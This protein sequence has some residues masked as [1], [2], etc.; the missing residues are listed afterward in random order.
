[1]VTS[2][3]KASATGTMPPIRKTLVQPYDGTT[4]A[5]VSPHSDAPIR[6]PQAMVLTRNALMRAGAYS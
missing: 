4:A 2:M 3:N 5:A 1:M 6:A